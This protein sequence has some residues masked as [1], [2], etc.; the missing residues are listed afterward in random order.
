MFVAGTSF[1]KFI[2]SSL[3]TLDKS[4]CVQTLKLEGVSLGI[5]RFADFNAIWKPEEYCLK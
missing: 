4:K 1:F 2:I 3:V 5:W